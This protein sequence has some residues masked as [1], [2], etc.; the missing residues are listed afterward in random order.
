ML[1]TSLMFYLVAEF[2]AKDFRHCCLLCAS[3]WLSL[4]IYHFRSMKLISICC[5]SMFSFFK[6]CMQNWMKKR[7]VYSK[8]I[9]KKC[10]CVLV[11]FVD[12]FFINVCV[13]QIWWEATSSVIFFHFIFADFPKKKKNN[14]I[15]NECYAMWRLIYLNNNRSNIDISKKKLFIRARNGW[16]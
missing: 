6:V 16:S 4:F 2:C 1:I 7:F 14:R 5:E 3:C 11:K 15:V 12:L 13:A 9:W 8:S 10:F